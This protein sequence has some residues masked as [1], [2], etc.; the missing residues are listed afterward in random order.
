MLLLN[1][2]FPH[3]FCQRFF[4][5][6]SWYILKNVCVCVYFRGCQHDFVW[7]L[8]H[9]LSLSVFVSL[10]FNMCA[11]SRQSHVIMQSFFQSWLYFL[12]LW[13]RQQQQQQTV[14]EKTVLFTRFDNI[15]II[16]Y[17]VFSERV[18]CTYVHQMW[19]HR[20]FVTPPIHILSGSGKKNYLKQHENALKIKTL[21]DG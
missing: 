3:N 2:F 13:T 18:H 1:N 4:S 12:V 16:F 7:K 17:Y 5:T 11:H 20:D 10:S 21:I 14:R 15:Q 6:H 19:F 8:V 9:I